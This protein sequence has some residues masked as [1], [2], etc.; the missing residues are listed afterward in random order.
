MTPWDG[1]AGPHLQAVTKETVPAI[2]GTKRLVPGVRV[3]AYELDVQS[4]RNVHQ[5]VGSGKGLH[6]SRAANA[7]IEVTLLRVDASLLLRD[8]AGHGVYVESSAEPGNKMSAATWP[9]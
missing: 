8:R 9:D 6:S 4:K 3:R 5:T 2:G 1:L 7:L